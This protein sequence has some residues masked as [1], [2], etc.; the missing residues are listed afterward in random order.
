MDKVKVGVIGG[1]WFGKFHLENLLKMSDVDVIAFATGNI[2]RLAALSQ[3]SPS[4]RTYKDQKDM[5][6]NEPELDA[7]IVC[8]PP[9]RHEAIELLVSK[10]KINMFMEKPLGV[11]LSEVR[12][13][14]Q[15]I[16]DS[17]IICAVDYQTRYN[18]ELDEIKANLDGQKVGAVVAKWIGVMPDTPWWSIKERSGGQVMEQVTHMIDALRYLFGDISTIYAR[19]L[20]GLISHL[21]SYNIEDCSAATITFE[22]GILA[23]LMSGCYLDGSKTDSEI[24]FEIYTDRSK[25]VFVWDTLAQYID[26]KESRIVKFGNVYHYPALRTFIE[27]V[28]S[29]DPSHIRSLYSDATKTSTATVAVNLSMQSHQ[30]VICKNL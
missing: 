3:K 21:P 2:E 13:C 19:S 1:G 12:R 14:E 9:Y 8:V 26:K 25:I 11:S 5:I 17:G 24:Q 6:E 28:K 18:P 16:N 15:A 20:T 29:N 30:E 27:A 4:A 23:T 22:N 7:V 10:H